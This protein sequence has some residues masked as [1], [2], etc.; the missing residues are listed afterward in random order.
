MT[1]S[2]ICIK[3]EQFDKNNLVVKE[4]TL[5]KKQNISI[6]T[7]QILFR[8]GAGDE[9]LFYIALPQVSTYEPYPNKAF[10]SKPGDDTIESYTISYSNDKMETLFKKIH[11]GSSLQ[12]NYTLSGKFKIKAI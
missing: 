1:F 7:S 9:C 11:H 8:N 3:P 4:A 10:N 2:T 12:I 5:Y 6:R